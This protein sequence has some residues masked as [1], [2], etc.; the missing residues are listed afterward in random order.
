MHFLSADLEAY[1]AANSEP[2]PALL[3]ELT[4]ETHLKVLMPRMITGHYQGRVLSV[5]SSLL[6]PQAILEIGTYTGY[7]ALCLAE[8]LSPDGELI[9]ID[10]NDELA[11]IQTR[12]FNRSPYGSQ[13][14]RLTGL[15]LEVL[16]G[17]DKVFDLVFID[18]D[19]TEYPEYFEQV[20]PKV[21]PGGVILL[22]NV[23]WSGKVV[24][25]VGAKD[26]ITPVLIDFNKR[27][28]ED[29]RVRT[30]LLPVRDGLTLCMVP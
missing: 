10:K 19:K 29:T 2:E 14:Q 15:A 13:I 24:E 11:G 5:I 28:S 22:D 1:I 6:R 7:S 27:L 4:R 17:I 12:Y 21:R 30:V 18:A 20:L 26:L 3:Q 25:P 23:L 8:G 9:T 16:P